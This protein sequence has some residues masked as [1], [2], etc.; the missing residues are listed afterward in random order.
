MS[1]ESNTQAFA[2]GVAVL[3][4]ATL[5]VGMAW[6][7][8]L[9]ES[10]VP[11]EPE[12]VIDVEIL[13]LPKLGKEAPKEA[14]PRIEAPAPP[15]PPPVEDI[16][17]ISRKKAQEELERKEKVER[18]KALERKLQEED[19]ARRLEKARKR[20]AA[21]DRRRRKRKLNR[22][23]ED[24]ED[25]ERADDEDAPGLKEGLANGNS[26]NRDSLRNK[27]GYV[28]RLSLVLSRQLQMPS[29]IPKDERSGLE[30]HVF[31]RVGSNGKLKGKPKLVRKSGNAYFDNAA[32]SA[33]RKFGGGSALKIPLPSKSNHDLRRFVLR[34]G[35][36][37]R[38]KAK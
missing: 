3:I 38:M 22:L 18:E 35:I 6:A 11:E 24:I 32:L 27:A 19:E 23:L 2:V 1:S 12:F 8:M 37:A 30:A 9:G 25:D 16:A 15:E 10:P 28:N 14:L 4:N 33:V 7:G 36:T 21:K 20:K 26:T 17:S 13:E 31:L 5:F 34:Q 29:V